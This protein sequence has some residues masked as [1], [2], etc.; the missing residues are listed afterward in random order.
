MVPLIDPGYNT[1][2]PNLQWGVGFAG[3]KSNSIYIPEGWEHYVREV[4]IGVPG[5]PRVYP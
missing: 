4:D 2:M 5:K 1:Y 3:W